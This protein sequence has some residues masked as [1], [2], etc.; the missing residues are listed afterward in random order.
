MQDAGT[1]TAFPEFSS[2]TAPQFRHKQTQTRKQQAGKRPVAIAEQKAL[3]PNFFFRR[4]PVPEQEMFQV[5][6]FVAGDPLKML[7]IQHIGYGP[8][9]RTL[10]RV[11]EG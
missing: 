4:H 8:A 6:A 11:D 9:H 5:M 7:F 1:A 2:Q 3:H 10:M